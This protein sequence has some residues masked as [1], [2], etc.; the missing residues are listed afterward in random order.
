MNFYPPNPNHYRTQNFEGTDLRGKPFLGT[1]QHAIFR[2]VMTGPSPILQSFHQVCAVLL[3]IL[4][5][6]TTVYA[7]GIFLDLFTESDPRFWQL[8]TVI[9]IG[10][11]TFWGFALW[12]GLTYSLGLI[13][14]IAIFMVVMTVA[15]ADNEIADG[16]A[17]SVLSIGGSMAGIVGLAEGIGLTQALPRHLV[18]SILGL[19]LGSEISVTKADRIW[20]FAIGLLILGLGCYMG[21]RTLRPNPDPRYKILRTLAITFATWGSTCFREADLTA[22]DFS[23]ATLRHT[24]FSN[25]ILTRTRWHNATFHQNNLQGTYLAN[26]QICRLVTELDGQGQNIATLADPSP[27]NTHY[28][29]RYERLVTQPRTDLQALFETL[30]T[31]HTQIRFLE[32]R[33]ADATDSPLSYVEVPPTSDTPPRRS[34]LQRRRDRLNRAIAQQNQHLDNWEEELQAANDQWATEMDEA[35]RTRL[36]RRITQLDNNIATGE[37]KLAELERQLDD[38]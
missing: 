9:G 33:I 35:M 7:V 22:A 18:F 10:I 5:G 24:D 29:Q 13:S 26:P 31:Q 16:T 20:L 1:W 8:G 14:F 21:K 23:N 2:Q 34:A 11:V 28:F 6:F 4:A 37:E 12:K 30:A 36:Q 19:V 25:A 3:A 32:A 17:I 38:I 27:L 15:I